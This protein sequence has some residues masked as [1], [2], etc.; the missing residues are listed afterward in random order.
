MGIEAKERIA[1]DDENEEAWVC[2]CGNT[3]T[4]HG[5]HPCDLAGNEMEPAKGWRDLYL[6]AGC[7]RIVNQNTLEVVGRKVQVH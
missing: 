2:V 1:H 6:C 5:F 3:P 4:S 7:G